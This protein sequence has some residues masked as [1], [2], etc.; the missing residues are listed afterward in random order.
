MKFKK[1]LTASAVASALVLAGCTGDIEI[2]EGDEVV[3]VNPD[4][5]DPDTSNCPDFATEASAIGSFS[6]VCTIDADYTFTANTTLTND[7][8]WVLQGRTAVGNDNTDSAMLTIE[9]GTT[10]IGQSGDDFLVV[11]RGS[12]IAANGTLAQPIIMTSRE[13]V[14]GEETGIGQWGGVVLL[15]NAPVNLCDGDGDLV[16]EADELANCG[17][18][19]EGDAGLY[20]GDNPNDDSGNLNYVIV[21]HAGNALSAGDELNGI[22]F[23]GVGDG[24]E[25][26]FIQVHENLDDGI[27]FFGG[28]VN[29]KHVVLTSNGD[30][31]LDWAFGWTGRAQHVYIQHSE[32]AANR[33][34]ESDNSE[35]FPLTSPV[36][37]PMVSNIT[38]VGANEPNGDSEGILLRHGTA[39]RLHNVVVT[40]PSGMGECLEVDSFEETRDNAE[41]GDLIMTNSAIACDNG[42]NFKGNATSTQTTEEW[43]L[44]QS[45]NMAF[46]GSASLNLD[47]NGYEPL[48]GSPLLGAGI[49]ASTVDAWFDSTDYI[50]AFDGTSDWT[51]GW[52]VGV[53]G[54]FP[55][56]I[57]N[58]FEKGLATDASSEFPEITDKPVY[59]LNENVVFTEDTTLT[60]N[61]HW[62]LNGRTAVGNDNA[63]QT[64]LYVQQ[65]TYLIGET[66]DD[67]LVVRRGSKIEA[68]GTVGAPIIM[69]SIQDVTGEETGIGQWGGLVLLG[70]AP[71]NLCDGNGD[72]TADE[73]ELANC[74]IAA[75]GDAGLYGGNDPEDNSG[76][77]KFVVV[78]H[79]GKALAA[80][81][82]LNGISFAGVGRGTT[83][84][85]IQVH[86]NLDDGVEFFGGT[87]DVK[88]VVLTGNGDDSF[89]WA[90]G[91]TGRA[92]FVY[93]QHNDTL[94]NRGF[95][96]DNSEDFPS[97]EPLTTPTVANVTIIGNNAPSEDSEGV[98]LRHGTAGLLRNFLITGPAGM[99]E[100]LEVDSFAETRANAEDGS[101][102][103]THSIVACENGENF[104]GT[105][106]TSGATTEQWFLGQTGNS[107]FDNVEA[108]NLLADGFTPRSGSPLLG[109]GYD[110]SADDDWFQS[111]DYIGAFD[112]AN[113]WMEGWTYGVNSGIP[114]NIPS[115]SDRGLATDASSQFPAI[116]DKP[117][118]KFA[119][120]TTITQDTVL[121]NDKHW[122][123]Q[124][125]TAVGND[126]ADSATLYIEPGTVIFGEVGDDFLVARRGSKI[127]ALGSATA[128]IIMTSVQDVTGEA[129]T[130]GQWGGLVLLGN[131]PVNLCDG[132]G[133]GDTSSS[134]LESCGIAAE[135]DAGV[136]GG[137]D[138][139][140]NSGTLRYV[141]VKYAGKA[142]AAGDE[143][144][145]ISF[146]GVGRGTTVDY[147]QVHKNLDDGVE[148][149]GGTVD[150][151]HLVLTANGDD[152]FD[153]AFGWIGRAQYVLI[154]HDAAFVNRGIEGDNSE[155]FPGTAPVTDPIVANFT[156]IGAASSDSEGVLLRH[157]TAGELYNF[158]ITGPGG[159][160]EC[161]EVDSFTET[162]ANA[163]SGDL[164]MENSVVACE[165]G[166]NFKGMA[167]S[168]LT[169]EDWFLGQT[170]NATAATMADVVNGYTTV[171]ANAARDM[172][173]VDSWFDSVDFVGAVNADNDWTAG[174]IT[175]G[176]AD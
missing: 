38:I 68:V 85:Y 129:T 165:N 43:F 70:N 107:A 135:G 117:V 67:F 33:G 150:V 139:E 146:A 6:N 152:S 167:T 97:A 16:A 94:A 126:N 142:L 50:G 25:V 80:G 140:D 47:P 60:N 28:T 17:I 23:A 113:N 162:Q 99:G 27:E 166:E 112:G 95:E 138:P 159:M 77:L 13:D 101:L 89:D 175:V 65:G 134:E 59:R 110:L 127:E 118:Y 45:G 86:E 44:A 78:K 9:A 93:I 32:T 108:L 156:I 72:N 90:F 5:P 155:D 22:T 87:V 141:V 48:A 18:S 30:D 116:T 66:G 57:D 161:L 130:V 8:L 64:T 54:G 73:T 157:G 71:S 171:S 168:T 133:D 148:F 125:R 41:A 137:N 153:W 34:F 145:G 100:C 84:D 83:V 151:K 58:A 174:W 75:E 14:A 36:S 163:E 7:T 160:G 114:A 98:L 121:T 11:R 10:I 26:D 106:T 52:A 39:G 12:Q 19:A 144:N 92:Q 3:V 102:A 40:G 81:D 62:I 132:N 20:G 21:K 172:N 69:T 15:G 115:A 4:N 149:F 37:N 111:T 176:L 120:D 1:I 123:L 51:E 76:T 143:L 103:M 158:V 29:V 169:T 31:S 96:S 55:A 104:K 74:G 109:S 131:A 24:T 46:N 128:P 35:D 122:V 49:D 170:G 91:W 124:G 42:E 154:K 63:D 105:A 2:K 61:A 79:A 88:H 147:I 164:T 56:N 53:S 136:Y 82:E 119:A 173:A